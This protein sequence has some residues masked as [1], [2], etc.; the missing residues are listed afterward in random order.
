MGTYILAGLLRGVFWLVVLGF[1]LWICRKLF[2]TWEGAL[3]KVGAVEGIRMVIRRVLA[4]ARRL[5]PE[6]PA[7]E[8]RARLDQDPSPSETESRRS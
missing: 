7:L 1:G 8:E 2:P 5:H 4:A 6:P 3:F